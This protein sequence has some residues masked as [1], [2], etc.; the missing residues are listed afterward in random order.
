MGGDRGKGVRHG[1]GYW[2]LLGS[3]VYFFC[4]VIVARVFMGSHSSFVQVSFCFDLSSG[5]VHSNSAGEYPI[6]Y[7]DDIFTCC[8]RAM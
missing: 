8:M 5:F 6:Y 7:D 1:I 4:L 3:E 2:V